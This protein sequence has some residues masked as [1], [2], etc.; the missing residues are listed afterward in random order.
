MLARPHF[1]TTNTK[2]CMVNHAKPLI[3]VRFDASRL[4][5]LDHARRMMALSWFYFP[6]AGSVVMQPRHNRNLESMECNTRP[7]PLGHLALAAL[8]RLVRT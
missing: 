1:I 3:Y 6:V 4:S 7:T 5:M 2:L 8:A